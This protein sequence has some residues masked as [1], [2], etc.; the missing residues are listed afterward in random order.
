[1]LGTGG[2]TSI[3]QLSLMVKDLKLASRMGVSC[4][5]PMLIANTARNFFE[6]AE[7]KFRGTANLDEMAHLFEEMAGIDFSSR[8]AQGNTK[9][10]S[11]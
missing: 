2:Q 10:T 1:M 5:A 4:G 3:F 8:S 11:L 9:E 6:A 7:Q